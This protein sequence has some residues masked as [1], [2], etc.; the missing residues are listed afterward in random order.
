M[1]NKKIFVWIPSWTGFPYPDVIMNIMN[2]ELPEWYELY[3]YKDNIISGRPIHIARNLL[4][5]MFMQ[6]WCDYLWFCDDD[7]PP[8]IDTLKYLI[9]CNEDVATALVPLR[10]WWYMLNVTVDWDGCTSIEKYWEEKFE[11]ENFWTGCVL[12]SRKIIQDMCYNTWREPYHFTRLV[13]VFNEITQEKEEYTH[14]DIHI[15]WRQNIYKHNAFEIEKQYVDVS[16]DLYFWM[17][18]KDLWYRFYAHPLARCRH[19]KQNKEFISV[20]NQ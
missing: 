11:V 4:V 5:S 14:Q 3:F 1:D 19:Y 12:L 15:N 20:R 17:I 7:N 2:Q 6:S 10:H 16:E 13:Y 9:E 18:A 8:S